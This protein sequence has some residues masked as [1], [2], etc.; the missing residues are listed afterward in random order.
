[1]YVCKCTYTQ[2][3]TCMYMYTYIHI[4]VYTNTY[5]YKTSLTAGKETGGCFW[6]KNAT[7]LAATDDHW[8]CGG[9]SMGSGSIGT[10]DRRGLRR[11]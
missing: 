7:C 3:Y 6:K 10:G 1:M 2:L 4:F 9:G 11:D 5:T 8:H